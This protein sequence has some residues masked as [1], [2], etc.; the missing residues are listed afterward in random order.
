MTLYIQ[1]WGEFSLL[2]AGLSITTL[3][4]GLPRYPGEVVHLKELSLVV[5]ALPP[6]QHYRFILFNTSTACVHRMIL[7]GNDP[8]EI[9][10][11][12]I[13]HFIDLLLSGWIT[14]SVEV[15]RQ[16]HDFWRSSSRLI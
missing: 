12:E 1:G 7:H 6:R 13:Q 14:W 10:P 9:S 15:G 5:L 8:A 2:Q 3:Y 4:H 11:S 16:I